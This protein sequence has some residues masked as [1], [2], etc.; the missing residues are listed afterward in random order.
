M[1]AEKA[2][3]RYEVPARQRPALETLC[4]GERL[5][6]RADAVFEAAQR[7]RDRKQGYAR[8]FGVKRATIEVARGML[9]TALGTAKEGAQRSRWIKTYQHAARAHSWA[10]AGAV[11][12]KR[13]KR[14]VVVR[15]EPVCTRHGSRETRQPI[16]RRGDQRTLR[17]CAY[18]DTARDRVGRRANAIAWDNN[19][20]AGFLDFVRGRWPARLT[21]FLAPRPVAHAVVSSSSR[22]V[23]SHF[24][25]FHARHRPWKLVQPCSLVDWTSIKT[26]PRY[27]SLFLPQRTSSNAA[28]S[29]TPGG[30]HISLRITWRLIGCLAACPAVDQGL[31]SL[32]HSSAR[33][34]SSQNGF[35][36]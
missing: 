23:S 29:C 4:G 14:A 27:P 5:S 16:A 32:H 24:L 2:R 11:A 22:V 17:D 36:R 30:S 25:N 19:A 26:C 21:Q 10:V 3:V 18:K 13:G 9:A 34:S 1:M 6:R 20:A 8:K 28:V 31:L 7:G 35:Q 15:A 33:S 12:G